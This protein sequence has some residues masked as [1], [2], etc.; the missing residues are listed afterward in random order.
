MTVLFV[1]GAGWAV[2]RSAVAWA[3]RSR[4]A[5]VKSSAII[6][7]Q[8]S[9]PNVMFIQSEFRGTLFRSYGG[10]STP[11]RGGGLVHELLT[12]CM[13]P[14]Q[15]SE[16]EVS[17]RVRPHPGPLLQERENHSPPF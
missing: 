17:W 14:A 3:A 8:P 16:G 1:P 10:K 13:L 7:R 2:Q 9:V 5:N 12:T 4:L 6:A 15:V 11:G